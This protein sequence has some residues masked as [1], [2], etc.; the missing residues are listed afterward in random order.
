[1]NSTGSDTHQPRKLVGDEMENPKIQGETIV[2]INLTKRSLSQVIKEVEAVYLS[3][4]LT[5]TAGNKARAA[6]LAGMTL[7]TF[8]RKI[9]TYTISTVWYL[10]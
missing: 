6:N 5:Q 2:T 9:N 7:D 8:R 1:M 4:V 10:E 3:H